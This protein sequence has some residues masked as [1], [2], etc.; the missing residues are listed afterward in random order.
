MEKKKS[1]FGNKHFLILAIFSIFHSVEP[2]ELSPDAPAMAA[3]KKSL[4]PTESLGWSDPNPCKWNH[5][6]CS[7][8]NRVTRIQIGRQNLQGMLPSNIQNL[9]ALERLELQWNKISGPLPSLSGLAS[10][11]VLLLSGNQFT[12]IPADFFAGM[13]SLQAVEIDE[14]PFSAW[15]IPASLRNAS[16]LQNF[17]AN[18]ANVT[19][20]IPEFLGSE[21]IPGLTNLHLAFNSLQGGLPS[22]FSG[23]QLESLWVNGQKSVDKLS[24]SVDVLQNMTSLIEVWLH[25]NSFSGPLP[26]FSRLKDLQV[27]S[28]RDNKFTGPVPSSLVNSP[29]LKVVNLTNN[30]LQGPIPLFKTGVVVDLTNDSNSFCL[31][32]TGECDSRVNTLLSIVKFMGYPQRFAENWKGND[33][34]AEWIGISCRNQS[35]T[36]IN[37]QKMGLSGV[38]SPEFASLKGLERLVLADNNLTGSIPEELTTLPF[39]TELDVSNNQLS[40]KIPKFRSN[41]M[42]TIT[43]NPDIGKEKSDSSSNGASASGSSNDRK[44]AGSNG[45]GNSGNG[46]NSMVGV[47]VLSVVGGVFVLF[48]I[49]LVVL[50]VYKMKQ[51]RFSQ[52]QS[53]NAMVIHPRHSGS[54]NESVK[55]TVAGSSVR[56][57]A[58]SETQYGA[59]SET[60]DIQMV[61]AGN[62]VISIQVLKNVTNNFS[63]ENI[64]GQGGFGTVYKGELHDGTKIAVKRMES[65]VIKGKGLTEFKSEIAVLTKVR[66]RHLVAL[67]GYCLDGNEKL[68]VYEYMPQGTLSRHLFNWPEEGLKPLEWTKR[69]TIALDV[70]RGVE[71]LHGLAHQSFIHRDLKPSNILLGDDMRAKVADFGLVRLAP[72]GK[73]SIETRIAGTFGYLAPEYAVTGRVTTK[74]DVF[75][76]GVILME[77]ITGRKALDES[78]PEESMHLVTWFRRMQINKDSFHKAIDPTIDLTEETFASINTVAELAGHCCAREPYQRPDMGHAVNVLSSLVEFWKPT[79]QNSEDIYGIDLEMSLPQALKKWQAYEGRSQMESSSSSLLPS[80]DNTQTSIPTRPYGFAESFTSAD[81]R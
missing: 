61:E 8:D 65:G 47:I 23:S 33:P 13:T 73:G 74:V 3:L 77:L 31:Q 72:E 53:P 27:L 10:L 12:S 9:T 80:F 68:L 21:D 57:G 29:S 22:S 14:N 54:D 69:L 63:E 7:D 50:C 17:S 44:E 20:R 59:S 75:S 70:A 30:L 38:I 26:D 58:I 67:L 25:S 45:G 15:E 49:G 11:Q 28:L 56:V 43:G 66:H 76:F 48:L 78:Q 51:K 41:V 42:M 18:S 55:I 1:H 64:L 79:D 37:F 16:T 34:C 81:G 39:L 36:I 5:V 52:V 62:M 24:G 40:G 60:G 71:Y 46:N 2:Q 32:D 6:L 19:G 35:I 4:N